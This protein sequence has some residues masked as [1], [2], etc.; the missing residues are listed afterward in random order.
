[1]DLIIPPTRAA[2]GNEPGP[3]V[4]DVC[5]FLEDVMHAFQAGTNFL[6]AMLL[7]TTTKSGWTKCAAKY[8]I[9]AALP[10]IVPPP[11]H[12]LSHGLS[13]T[14]TNTRRRSSGSRRSSGRGNQR[15]LMPSLTDE[16]VSHRPAPAPGSILLSHEPSPSPG[17]QT[18][19]RGVHFAPDPGSS[20]VPGAGQTPKGIHA[21]SGVA[22]TSSA[23]SP[24][25]PTN[26]PESQ[27]LSSPLTQGRSS[28]SLKSTPPS[29]VPPHSPP[30][31]GNLVPSTPYPSPAS[32]LSS[33]PGS[34]P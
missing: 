9:R 21:T 17:G 19:S 6:E 3:M 30:T 14:S 2:R 13:D 25:E 24:A 32:G 18:P 34:S 4:V 12:G 26:S 33:G 16:K 31:P 22:V 11:A 27:T 20:V 5:P 10:S 15:H 1:M 28:T 8:Q 29:S 7:H 23:K